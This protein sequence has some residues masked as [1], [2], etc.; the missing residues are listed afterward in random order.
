MNIVIAIT[1][2]LLSTALYAK[3]EKDTSLSAEYEVTNQSNGKTEH[4]RFILSRQAN[5][6]THQFPDKNISE[7]WSL[8]KNGRLKMSRFFD[9]HQRGIEYEAAEIP[10]NSR[11]PDWKLKHQLI[12][13][14]FIAAMQLEKKEGMGCETIEHY[15]LMKGETHVTLQWMPERNLIKDLVMITGNKKE[16]WMLDSL[17]TNKGVVKSKFLH[18]D[19]M[20]TTDYADVGDNE[21]DPFLMNMINL[22]FVEHGASGFYYSSGDKMSHSG[23]TH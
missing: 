22:G 16:I 21:S 20:Q 9:E 7:V 4:S 19:L 23:H 1:L 6:V 8:Q 2:S 11:N 13:N 17:I 10:E 12:T 14:K 15:S 18:W 5:S 3:C